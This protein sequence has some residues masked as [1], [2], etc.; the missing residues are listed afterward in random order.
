MRGPGGVK[1]VACQE[2]DGNGESPQN[3][4]GAQRMFAEHFQHVGKQGNAGAEEKQPG[5]IQ[6]IGVLAV[7]GEMAVDE[8]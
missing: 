6:R 2:E 1:S 8:V 7:V 5:H 4:P 3:F